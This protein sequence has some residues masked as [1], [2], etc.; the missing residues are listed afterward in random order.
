MNFCLSTVEGRHACAQKRNAG[1]STLLPHPSG[2]DLSPVHCAQ[3]DRGAGHLRSIRAG[4]A[5]A[6]AIPF[7]LT[8]SGC[9]HHIDVAP[10][11]ESEMA[12]PAVAAPAY[13]SEPAPAPAQSGR[14]APAPAPPGG[15]SAEDLRYVRTHRPILTEEGVATWYTAPYKGRKAANGQVFSDHALTAA[16]RTLPMGS[17]IKVTNLNT[18]QSAAMRITDRGPFVEGRLIDLTIASAK[19][20][21]VYP[22]GTANVRVDVYRTPKPIDTGGR[23]CVQIGAFTSEH[24][25]DKLKA[26]LKRKYPEASVIDFPGEK[27]YWVRIRPEGDNREQA[28]RI[29]HHL[30]PAEGD[31]FLTRLD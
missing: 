24:K 19:A 9:V 20:T 28:E 29:A 22:A 10:L 14:I 16:H 1:P 21:G 23:W 6:V 18:G 30:R 31:A 11:P 17:L 13:S 4:L 12:P 15:V 3:D 25:A 27:S 2:E 26:Q 7:L 5:L 8:L